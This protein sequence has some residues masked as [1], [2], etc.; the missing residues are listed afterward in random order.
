MKNLLRTSLYLTVF[1]LAGILFQISCSA[2]SNVTNAAP[3]GKI[4]YTKRVNGQ[5]QIWTCSYDG[6]NQAQIPITLPTNVS[7][8]FFLASTT[9][10]GFADCT[11][12]KLSPDGQKVFFAT[13]TDP[14][15]ANYHFSIYSCDLSGNNLTEILTQAS[16]E[17]PL[18]IGGVY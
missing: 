8:N 10:S 15:Q 12:V 9:S 17:E 5:L 7:Y 18:V 6:S 3:L 11:Y 4:V 1:A 14:F 2:D 16:G 13:V